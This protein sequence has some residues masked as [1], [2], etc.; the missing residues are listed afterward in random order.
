LPK[1]RNLRTTRQRRVILEEIRK[2][3]THPSA[4]E[5]YEMVRPLLPRISLGTV[6]RNLE[7]LSEIGEIQKLE[8]GGS[9]KRFDGKTEKHY[10]IR[11]M[12]C[13]R[14][15]DAP[16]NFLTHIENEVR[17]KTGFRILGHQLEFVGLC[18]EC[19]E[20][21]AARWQYYPENMV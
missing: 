19:H 4:D 15:D 13:D 20:K 9:L 1:K 16:M 8:Y 21:A 2:T 5:V 11:C 17:D 7:I 14:L 12:N 10:H 3:H 6:Y 18:P